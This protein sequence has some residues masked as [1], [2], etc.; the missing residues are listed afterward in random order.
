MKSGNQMTKELKRRIYEFT[1]RKVKF[2]ENLPNDKISMRMQDQLFR[3]GTSILA[4]YVEGLSGSSKRDFAKFVNISL[5]STNESKFWFSLIKDT[6]RATAE[7]VKW[8]LNELDEYS[9]IF[10]STLIT[11]RKV[12]Q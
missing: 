8:F 1:I 10:G 6:G 11:I 5:K 4:N 3:S 9:K 12:K 7:D 2:L